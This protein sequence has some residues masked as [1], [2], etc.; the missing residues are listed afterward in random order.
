[1]G[2]RR[3]PMPKVW[4][5]NGHFLSRHALS[6]SQN[7]TPFRDLNVL[8]ARLRTR[9]RIQM[10]LLGVLS[11]FSAIAEVAMLGLVVPFLA[12]V[13][14]PAQALNNPM[15]AQL[16]RSLGLNTPEA[17]LLPVTAGFSAVAV[18]A[19]MIR[20]LLLYSTLRFTNGLAAELSADVYRRTLYQSYRVHVSRSTAEVISTIRSKVDGVVGGIIQP[21]LTMASAGILLLSVLLTLFL[22]DP[23]VAVGATVCFGGI[24]LAST[25]WTRRKIMRLGK[26]MSDNQ[27]LVLRAL[28]EGLHGIRDVL[29]SGAQDKY[30]DSYRAADYPQRR[31]AGS[32]A[33]LSQGMR[34]VV[35]VTAMVLIAI[36][37]Y[38]LAKQPG[39]AA[40]SIPTLGA[41]ALGGQR[42][43]PV[44]Q[45]FFSSWAI[46]TGH[47]HYLRDVLAA[48]QQPMPARLALSV[49]GLGFSKNLQLNNVSY[50]YVQDGPLILRNVTLTIP[51]GSRV[52]IVGP[53][54]GGKST[55]ADI[56]MGLLEPYS[57]HLC[58]DGVVV[59]ARN[60]ADWQ[61]NVAHVPQSI[62]LVDGTFAE[63]I[64]IGDAANP[65]DL[66]RVE[67]AAIGAQI[68]QYIQEQAGGY[69]AVTG[70]NGAK[71]SGGQRQRVGIA[72]ALYKDAK[73]L[74]LDEATS[75]LDS[76]TESLIIETL[77]R[78]DLTMTIVMI[79]H[80]LTTLRNCDIVIKVENG[81]V[82]KMGS[83]ADVIGE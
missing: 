60:V 31:A 9:R 15:V 32:I 22:I 55:L 5:P 56:I 14:S 35:E 62:Y 51:R 18:S 41:V 8:L 80:R 25:F 64:A 81:Q 24:Y 74:V 79:A 78:Q 47:S 46:I 6:K 67:N 39:G 54:G 4:P 36:F 82:T 49:G 70:E 75:A 26:V 72:R 52:G 3:V 57:G 48:L 43:L 28:Q 63:N 2:D 1:M 30:T 34:Y 59:N 19:G 58:V 77:G 7:Q 69:Q 38:T 17:L 10:F 27:A 53:T 45:Q 83:Y 37:A 11:I 73:L 42:L 44:L 61:R 21:V 23:R 76:Q 66:G 68:S 20:A 40:A 50:R 29:L 13:L 12:L 65:L 16:A 71:L 33:F